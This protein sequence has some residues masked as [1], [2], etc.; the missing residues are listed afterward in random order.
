MNSIRSIPAE[1]LKLISTF[2]ITQPGENKILMT[3]IENLSIENTKLVNLNS[4]LEKEIER[5]EMRVES[6]IHEKSYLESLLLNINDSEMEIE[7]EKIEQKTRE[8]LEKKYEYEI[9][10]LNEKLQELEHQYLSLEMK[11]KEQSLELEEIS[12]KNIELSEKEKYFIENYVPKKKYETLSME[13]SHFKTVNTNLDSRI[14]FRNMRVKELERKMAEKESVFKV[15]MEEIRTKLQKKMQLERGQAKTN[16]EKL[17]Q[18]L[19]Q[20]KKNKPQEIPQT[21]N[22]N[23]K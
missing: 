19:L 2:T 7:V 1:D 11:N 17:N 10:I 18:K 5:A 23:Q 4:E 16:I 21:T 15:R 8:V 3:K 13:L 6:L 14:L 12:I 20:T 22:H 9:Q